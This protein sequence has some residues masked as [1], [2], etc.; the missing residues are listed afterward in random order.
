M[1]STKQFLFFTIL[2]SFNFSGNAGEKVTI[3]EKATSDVPTIISTMVKAANEN[4]YTMLDQLTRFDFSKSSG[5][6]IIEF[7]YTFP[8]VSLSE[9]DDRKILFNHFYSSLYK[10]YCTNKDPI[11]VKIRNLGITYHYNYLSA[12][13]YKVFGFDLSPGSCIGN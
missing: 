5:T 7:N 1:T 6:N 12:D 2:I 3:K 8:Q 4:K 10:T 13:N 9:I 11:T